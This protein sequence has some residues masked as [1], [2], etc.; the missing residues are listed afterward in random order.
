MKVIREEPRSPVWEVSIHVSRTLFLSAGPQVMTLM[1]KLM[2]NQL[3]RDKSTINQIEDVMRSD[4]IATLNCFLYVEQ[5]R[6]LFQRAH[7]E[8]LLKADTRGMFAL[9]EAGIWLKRLLFEGQ[10]F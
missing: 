7:I 4:D 1:T 9:A 6:C 3:Q 8:S 2:N 10:R 5:T